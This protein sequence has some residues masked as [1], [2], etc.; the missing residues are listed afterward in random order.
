MPLYKYIAMTPDGERINGDMNCETE[1]DVLAMLRSNRFFP[2]K[3]TVEDETSM[4]NIVKKRVRRMKIKE[5]F[6]FCHQ[7]YAMLSSGI[8]VLTCLDILRFQAEKKPLRESTEK[9]FE[10]VQKGRML[11]EAMRSQNG[12][13]PELLVSMIEAGELSGNL[14]T[15]MGRM[16][17]HYEKEYRIR[18]KIMNAMIYPIVLSCIMISVIIF[19]LTFLLPAFMPMFEQSGMDLPMPTKILL[20]ISN[21][22][23]KYWY[24]VLLVIALIVYGIY[25]Y[26]KSPIGRT[27][28]DRFKL[29]CPVI[30]K[31]TRKV[32]VSRFSRT[33]STLVMSGMSLLD[34]LD[35]TAKVIN[36]R[37]ITKGLSEVRDSV[38]KGSTLYDPLKKMGLFSPMLY[39]MVKVGEESGRIVEMLD[40]TSVFFEDEFESAVQKATTLLEPVMIVVMAVVVGFIILSI[41][42]PIFNLYSMAGQ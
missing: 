37:I 34:A 3:I 30:G 35:V 22:I 12:V 18:S 17:I 26:V 40:K 15:M 16:A 19:L 7:F 32:A 27:A 11:S 2:V 38:R 25:L 1:A 41:I 29:K 42:L 8:Q 28:Y 36:N 23:T 33:L 39:S 24:L 9:L 31:L 21:I 10:E 13:F 20:V 4:A 6:L 5:T 14:D